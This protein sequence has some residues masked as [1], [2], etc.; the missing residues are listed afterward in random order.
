MDDVLVEM[1]KQNTWANLRLLDALE[2]LTEEQLGLEIPGTYGRIRDVV[3]HL[4]A[5]EQRYV[6]RLSGQTRDQV[7]SEREGFPSAAALREHARWSGDRLAAL[8]AQVRADEV[9]ESAYQGVTYRT[10][11]LVVLV[12]AIEHGTEHRA[13]ATVTMSFHGITPPSLDG[14]TYGQDAGYMETVG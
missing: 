5:A 1:F 9:F 10:R 7:L 4:L 13:H 6:Q 14:W 2:R 8:A 3:T 11:K 12:Q